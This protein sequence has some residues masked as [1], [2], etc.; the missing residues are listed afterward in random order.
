[1]LH[2]L[3]KFM[4]LLSGSDGI[5]NQILLSVYQLSH[6]V[7]VFSEIKFSSEI[8]KMKGEKS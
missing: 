7:K 3:P 6:T 1:M 8:L 2:S 4:Q 5:Q